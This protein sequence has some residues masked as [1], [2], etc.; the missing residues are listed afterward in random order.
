[1]GKEESEN[2]PAACLPENSYYVFRLPPTC[3]EGWGG[4]NRGNVPQ[5]RTTNLQFETWPLK[6]IEA[7]GM[8][9]S[10]HFEK[11][12]LSKDK[13]QLKVNDSLTLAKIP[14]E[15]LDYRLGQWHRG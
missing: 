14:P 10:Y 6:W 9:L 2:F 13:T 12:R 4:V 8:H 11:M 15:V 1:M 5:Q 7:E 3:G